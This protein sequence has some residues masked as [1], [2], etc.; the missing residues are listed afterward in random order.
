MKT[1]T[2]NRKLNADDVELPSDVAA[3]I[4]R[5]LGIKFINDDYCDSFQ[6]PTEN[7]LR[8]IHKL[9]SNRNIKHHIVT[10]N[11]LLNDLHDKPYLFFIVKLK[12]SRMHIRCYNNANN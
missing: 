4:R 8:R 6:V 12:N 1:T 7:Q 2:I 9:L 5:R 3:Y 11:I 10:Y